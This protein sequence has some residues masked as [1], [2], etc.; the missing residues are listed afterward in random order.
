MPAW[1]SILALPLAV[2]A[3]AVGV[4]VL[5][6]A[7]RIPGRLLGGLATAGLL[8]VFAAS[9]AFDLTGRAPHG[10]YVADAWVLFFQR[11]VLVAAALSLLGSI[12]WLERR[13]PGRQAEYSCLLLL[14]LVGMMLLPG[15]RDWL[16]LVVTFEL[17]GVPLYVLSAWEKGEGTGE[18]MAAEAGIKLFV[19]GA[20]S[21]AVSMFGLALVTGLTGTTAMQASNL[22]APLAT[23]G[24]MLV[25]AGFAFKIG[26][27]PFHF[28]VA[29]TYQGAPTPF[30]AFLSVAP[31]ATGLA[32][33]V[34]VLDGVWGG[35]PLN[36][37]PALAFIA[38]ASMA[39]G[40]LLALPQTDV[41][42]LL[43]FSG[44]AQ[45]GYVLVALAAHSESGV[46]MALF[47]IATYVFT[48]L[49]V[50]FVIHAA[51]EGAGSH[52]IANLAGLSRR[53]PWLGA[54]LL[55]FLL[56]LAGI[57]FVAG[58]WAKL[59]IFLAA[60]RAG[61]TGLVLAGVMLAVVGLFYYLQV[62]RSTFMAEG[63]SGEPLRPPLTL[64]LTIAA[65]LAAVVGMGLY[66][67][68]LLSQAEG[69]AHDL[70]AGTRLAGPDGQVAAR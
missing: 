42:R 26:A 69:A 19:T 48:N 70:I 41:R 39:V 59:F 1:L 46:A 21:S 24:M 16:L 12:D 66:P 54:A 22:T 7:L 3:L 6:A 32:A 47:F 8:A 51:A 57:P 53:S 63:T 9:F 36:W 37:T 33:F 31:K 10:V 61:L 20:T 27:V 34:M 68:P 52:Q 55:T 2:T 15:A 5:D 44:I 30:V 4:L 45:I 25:L 11:T 67:Q 14:S 58:F 13:T 29:D 56:S 65:C 23:V 18:R 38:A 43:G 40:N 50:F 17:M 64:Q 60:Y 62:A 49:G 35:A 28:W